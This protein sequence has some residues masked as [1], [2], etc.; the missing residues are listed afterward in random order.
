MVVSDAALGVRDVQRRPEMIRERLPDLIV[1]VDSDRIL[2]AEGARLRDDVVDVPLEP[3]LRRVD[4]DHRQPEV[5]AFRIPCT[6]VGQCAQPV[7]AGVRPEVDED[8]AAAES[9]FL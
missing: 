9:L 5:A 4:A 3:E 2:D 1:A 6:D 7:D 8:D